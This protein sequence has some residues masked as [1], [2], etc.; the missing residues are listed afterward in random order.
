MKKI[1]LHALPVRVW[2]WVNATSFFVLIGTG[3]QIRYRDVLNWMSFES[4]VDV[5]NLFGFLLIGNFLVWAGYY[6]V[7]R[8]LKLY[9]PDPNLKN[10]VLGTLRQ[11]R[12]YGYGIFL[13]E[14]NPH[15]ATPD[16]KFNPM[17]Q[18]AYF[19]IM[20]FLLPLQ[21][22]TGV[23][24]W[25]IKRFAAMIAFAGGIKFVDAVHVFLTLFFTAFLF[26]HVYL[27]TL[28]HKWSEHIKAMFTGYEEEPERVH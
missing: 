25:D 12:Y 20:L 7:T 8:K 26:V 19:N 10:F 2:H 21:I 11:A 23:L 15:H 5:H 6:L 9:I 3:A 18:V 27:A 1:Y 16:S 22:L 17:Q 28:G 13:G 4:A 24:M 14:R